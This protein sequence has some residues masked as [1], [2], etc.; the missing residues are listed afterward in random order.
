MGR[1]FKTTGVVRELEARALPSVR[2]ILESRIRAPDS[3][4]VLT[5]EVAEVIETMRRAVEG[6]EVARFLAAVTGAGTVV[7]VLGMR[8]LAPAMKGYARGKRPIEMVHAFVAVGGAAKGVGSSLVEAL[9]SR[10]R[11]DGHD[12]MLL[13]S[14][15]RYASTGWGFFDRQPGYERLG[16]LENYYGQGQHAP[17]WGR[18]L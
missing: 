15:P 7:G 10:A 16:V 2:R 5:D 6:R 18:W 3:G 8:P 9:E 17:V 11:Q 1:N 4:E 12:E 14:G 13:N